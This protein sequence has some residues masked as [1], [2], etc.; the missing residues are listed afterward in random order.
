MIPLLEIITLCVVYHIGSGVS[1]GLI[2]ENPLRAFEINET[3][4]AFLDTLSRL[5]R[6]RCT[7][8]PALEVVKGIILL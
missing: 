7:L 5:H 8:L 2:T 6:R 1:N 3:S 4:A